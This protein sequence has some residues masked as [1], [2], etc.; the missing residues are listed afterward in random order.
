MA[1]DLYCSRGDVTRR[2][3]AGTIAYEGRLVASVSTSAETL[4]LDGHGFEDDD[5]VTVRAAEGGSLPS[6]LVA[7]TVYYAIRSNHSRFQL[8]ATAGGAAINLTSAGSSFFVTREPP[9]DDLIEYYS[10]F[11]DIHLPAHV[12]PLTA[13]IHPL[14]KG[15]V[16]DLTAKRLLNID[17]KASAVV[18]AAEVAAKAVLA[19]LS[20][21]WPLRG[22]AEVPRANKAYVST[23]VGGT[24]PRGWGSE[25]L[26]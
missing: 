6:P 5:E 22:A 3:A 17:G 8:A 7:G 20:K 23:L 10:R 2:I 1:S 12:V 19:D 9:Y 14:V 4:E 24:D 15:I 21:S 25:T 16:A 26:P 18:D 11:C 13:P